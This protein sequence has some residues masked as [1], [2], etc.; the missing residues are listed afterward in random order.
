MPFQGRSLLRSPATAVT[1]EKATAQP[2]TWLELCQLSSAHL[3][4]LYAHPFAMLL[5]PLRP[6]YRSGE[7]NRWANLCFHAWLLQPMM[8]QGRQPGLPESSRENSKLPMLHTVKQKQIEP[9]CERWVREMQ[10]SHK[11]GQFGTSAKRKNPGAQ[12]RV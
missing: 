4:Q 12:S 2:G 10:S 7:S 1:A 8:P 9:S 6:C 5:N 3:L 11:L